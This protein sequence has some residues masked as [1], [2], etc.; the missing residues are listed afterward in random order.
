MTTCIFMPR[1]K[2]TWTFPDEGFGEVRFQDD[3]DGMHAYVVEEDRE[4]R[5]R[6][7]DTFVERLRQYDLTNGE[8]DIVDSFA[9]S[10][11]DTPA[12][13]HILE[14]DRPREEKRIR[15]KLPRRYRNR[16]DVWIKFN[17]TTST[18]HTEFAG[19][20][21][22]IALICVYIGGC[23]EGQFWWDGSRLMPKTEIEVFEFARECGCPDCLEA[24]AEMQAR[25]T[26]HR[27]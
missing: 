26:P 6:V 14:K 8:A 17:W 3:H 11:A 19:M 13:A 24:L 23:Y 16:D 18:P 2:H 7:D 22:Q 4:V 21:Q 9:L 10:P 20:N 5:Y 27:V 12:A 15:R 25:H 1:M